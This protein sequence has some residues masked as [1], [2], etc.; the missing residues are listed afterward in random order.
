M[1]KNIVA[2]SKKE[3]VEYLWEI[4]PA[5]KKI[6]KKSDTIRE[7][8]EKIFE[9]LN[10]LDRHYTSIY[11]DDY[12]KDLHIIE[13]NNARECIKILKNVIRTENERITHFSAL[14]ALMNLAKNKKDAYNRVDAGF[15]CEFI[16]LFTG[17]NGKSG[18]TDDVFILPLD[19]TEA[20]LIR[21]EKL[22]TYA[23]K[24][25]EY[26]RRYKSGFEPE[27]V[28]KQKALKEKILHY[29]QGTRSDW[30]N[31]HWQL[32][33][34]IREKQ[35]LSS[36]VSLED[37][38]LEGLRVAENNQIPFEITPYYLSLF[39]EK[40]QTG[41]D[42]AIRAQV[43]PSKTYCL[44]VIENRKKHIDM[45]FMGEKSTNPIEG[46]TRRYPQIVI[47]KPVNV[48]PQICVYCQRNWELEASTQMK[49]K[50]E[51]MN[52]AIEW[53]HQNVYINEVLV[54]GGDPFILPDSYLE[55]IIKK[56]A[57][58][59]HIERIRIGTR[60]IVTLP[61]RI[62]EELVN[63]MQQ[64]HELGKR[65]I[66]VMTH[67]EH[68][69]EITPDVLKAVKKIRNAGISIYN[70]QV[71][72]YYT[73]LKY[74]TAAL[75]KALKISG[76]D[77]YYTFNTKGKEETIDFRVPIARI[78]QERKEEARFLPGVI[79]TDES[80]FNVPKL[81]KSHLRAWQNHEIIMVLSSGQRV[82]RFYPWESSVTLVD[83]YLYT[84]VSI[85]DYLKRLD[86]DG[87]DIDEYKTIWY[88][89]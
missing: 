52:N 36:L 83:A 30:E 3:L 57:S 27:R 70:Q 65:E 77:P 81:G 86:H 33:H 31:Y 46:I 28:S 45:D 71:F 18:K 7:A 29:F 11:S 66:C 20:S 23:K 55:N 34:V 13:K 38:E 8:R 60:T 44:N 59:N 4:D 67:F 82:Y 50:E 87:Q 22:D 75:R 39:N 1:I 9:Y 72:T 62:T 25:N 51:D 69:F 47:L 88:Y 16:N 84:D 56:L 61:F 21:S 42:R 58:I 89:F 10:S 2:S 49:I 48:C 6:L 40:G 26:L 74:Q 14:N 17:I 19:D 5:I 78:E 64:Y 41:D 35:T 73:S 80:V 79:R 68:L 37:D 63:I 32:A 24:M 76:I 15:L 85:Y 12:F 53:I 43:L 54:T